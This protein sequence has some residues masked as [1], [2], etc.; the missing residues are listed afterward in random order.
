MPGHREYP[1]PT[2]TPTFACL[3]QMCMF[4]ELWGGGA[5]ANTATPPPAASVIPHSCRQQDVGRVSVCRTS[6]LNFSKAFVNTSPPGCRYLGFIYRATEAR[7]RAC[8]RRWESD[9]R[10]PG[11]VAMAPERHR[12]RCSTFSPFNLKIF[13]VYAECIALNTAAN[14][15]NSC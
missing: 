6:L 3:P 10:Q 1:T 2:P 13:S 7:R 8:R 14:L 5:T 4:L 12:S 9:L 11:V 15:C